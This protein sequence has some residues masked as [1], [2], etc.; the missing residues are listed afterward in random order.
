MSYRLKLCSS[1]DKPFTY[2]TFLVNCHKQMC[3]F[4]FDLIP[5]CTCRDKNV[6]GASQN[7]R[8]EGNE[9]GN[10]CYDW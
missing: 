8:S 10:W 1:V 5:V 6:R 9:S 4:I 2:K 3:F 7:I